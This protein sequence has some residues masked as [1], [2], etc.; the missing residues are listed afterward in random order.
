MQAQTRV[1]IKLARALN[2]VICAET[3]SAGA[4]QCFVFKDT[5]AETW[6]ATESI[7]A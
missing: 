2:L 4:K 5:V 6:S 7:F 1:S 3:S